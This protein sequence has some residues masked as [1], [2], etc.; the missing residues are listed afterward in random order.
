MECHHS[1]K[2]LRE[3]TENCKLLKK[4][5]LQQLLDLKKPNS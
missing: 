3:V 2:S 1:E 4:I 5:I